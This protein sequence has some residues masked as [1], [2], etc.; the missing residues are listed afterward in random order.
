MITILEGPDG[1]GK[2][3]LARALADRYGWSVYHQGPYDQDVIQETIEKVRGANLPTPAVFD[4]LHVGE[5]VYGPVY[6]GED[7]LGAAGHRALDRWLVGLGAVVVV[8]YPGLG[9]CVEAWRA[10]REREMLDDE[11]QLAEV[12]R[13]FVDPY[14]P[15]GWHNDGSV[16]WTVHNYQHESPAALVERLRPLRPPLN[17]GP[18]VGWFRPGNVLVVAEKPSEGEGAGLPF[19]SSH[20][21]SRWLN[22]KLAERWVREEHLYWVNARHADDVA[23]APDFLEDLEPSSVVALGAVAAE[24]CEEVARVPYERFDH[25][26]YH[27]RFHHHDPYPLISYLS[28]VTGALHRSA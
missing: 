10:R 14:L 6:R 19:V 25:P 9:A 26:Q 12:A 22:E 7:L 24:W 8:C 15:A 18:G 17:A 28:E 23:T 5:R 1:G 3:T 4:R 11:E 27:K 2:S 16:P 21:C 13:R 20:G